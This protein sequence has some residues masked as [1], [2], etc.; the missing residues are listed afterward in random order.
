MFNSSNSFYYTIVGNTLVINALDNKLD[1]DDKIYLVIQNK[2][3][4]SNYKLEYHNGYYR[5]N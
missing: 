1:K 4:K 3:Y 2:I 5:V